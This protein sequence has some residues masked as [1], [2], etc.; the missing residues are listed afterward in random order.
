MAKRTFEISKRI[1]GGIL[2][3]DI[4]SKPAT[5]N[6][7]TSVLASSLFQM[8]QDSNCQQVL[9]DLQ[10]IEFITSDV[11]GQLIMLHKKC[12]ADN[13]Q[14]KIC[15]ATAENR[16]ALD[17]VRF[18]TLVEMYDRKPHAITAFKMGERKPL[19]VEVDEGAASEY[20]ERAQAGDLDAQFRFAKCLETGCGVTQDFKAAMQWYQ[21]AANQ[22]HIDS[23]HS[24]GVAYAYGISVPQDFEAAFDWYKK[25]ADQGHAEAQYWVG[26]SFHHGLL[27][28]VDL[29]RAQKWYAEAADQG[30]SPA[31]E[32]LAEIKRSEADSS[33]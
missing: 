6:D 8:I 21:K 25:A 10:G 12:V 24:L 19:E 11:I 5:E 14:L 3:L 32:A 31:R 17:L 33:A 27:D 26:V 29:V 30:Y 28:E 20:A 7:S 1:I 22:G 9:L 4:K 23:Q 16:L 2:V 18:D 15:G 13:R